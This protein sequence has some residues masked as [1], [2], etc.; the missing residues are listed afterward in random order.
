METVTINPAYALLAGIAILVLF[1]VT[2]WPRVGLWARWRNMRLNTHRVHMEDALKHLYD[3]EYKNLVCTRQSISG[4]L[5]VSADEAAHVI[6][7][8][9]VMRLI[10]VVGDGFA[11]TDEGR[12]YALRVIRTH[13]LWER[14]LADETGTVETDW[15]AEAERKEHQLTPAQA[16]ALSVQMGNPR[17]DPHGDPIPTASGD[18]PAPQGEPMNRLHRGEHAYIIHMEDE[19]PAVY[20]QL[21]AQGLYPGVHIRIIDTSATRIH[22]E[23]DGIESVL[24]PLV[25]ANVTVLPV[26]EKIAVEGTHET[27]DLLEPGQSARVVS[28]SR[29]CRGLQRRRLM[30]LGLLPGTLVTAEM[31]SASGDPTAYNIRGA[32]IALRKSHAGMI[33]IRREGEAGS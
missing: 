12:S 21:V 15:H 4:A 19:P 11:L 25:A 3:C 1:G 7:R 27:L 23:A 9:E 22:F 29:R 24:A 16:D 30:D 5:G 8:L 32:T 14:Y 18:V 26:H 33:S 20:A 2:A 28:I 31:R 10:N 17:F 6:G 13:R